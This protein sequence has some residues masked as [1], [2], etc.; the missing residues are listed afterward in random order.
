MKMNVKMRFSEN[1]M[2]FLQFNTNTNMKFKLYIYKFLKRWEMV[3][4]SEKL[5]INLSETKNL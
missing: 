5:A 2:I 1:Y 4:K 3:G